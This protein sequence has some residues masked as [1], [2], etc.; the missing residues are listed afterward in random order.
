VIVADDRTINIDAGWNPTIRFDNGFASFWLMY[1]A[2]VSTSDLSVISWK[3]DLFAFQKVGHWSF[4]QEWIYFK[5]TYKN[6]FRFFA[7]YHN[8]GLQTTGTV[9]H[10]LINVTIGPRVKMPYG[11]HS[12][13][14]YGGLWGVAD[15]DYSKLQFAD[16]SGKNGLF[17]LRY[18]IRFY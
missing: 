18:T 17:F 2:T 7:Y 5:D 11:G 1:G 9:H 14:I 16:L 15:K 3:Y 10:D 13:E 6:W 8:V 12:L 4:D